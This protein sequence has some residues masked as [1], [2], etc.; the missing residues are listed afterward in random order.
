MNVPVDS[1]FPFKGTLALAGSGEYLPSMNGVDKSLL[2]RLPRPA[3]V[4]CLPTAAGTEG[5]DRLRYWLD[6]GEAHFRSLGVLSVESLR[7]TTRADAQN[8]DLIRKVESANFIYLSGG[9]PYY[10]LECLTGTPMLDAILDNLRD[11]G[12]V[13]GCSAGAMIFGERIPNRSFIGGTLPAIGLLPGHFI[14]PHYDEVPF[15]LRFALPHLVGNLTMLGVEANTVL[16]CS[17]NS[18]TVLGSGGVTLE[19][20]VEATRYTG[21]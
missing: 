2:A 7:V 15:V 13:A 3:R 21:N 19:H 12:V 10:L 18:F 8:T 17:N 4:V 20:G 16:A 6:L 9:K 11:G 14:I 1:P 5:E